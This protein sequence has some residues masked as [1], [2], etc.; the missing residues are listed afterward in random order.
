MRDMINTYIGLTISYDVD[1]ANITD[2]IE[3][4]EMDG[5]TY[6][7]FLSIFSA[8]INSPDSILILK[9]HEIK[10]NQTR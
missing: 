4:S 1:K 9:H 10:S 8:S 5:E 3:G 6:K 2:V 7:Q